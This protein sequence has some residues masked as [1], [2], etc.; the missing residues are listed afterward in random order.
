MIQ[1][2][3]YPVFIGFDPSPPPQAFH[4]LIGEPPLVIKVSVEALLNFHGIEK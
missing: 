3:L 1:H 4:P 2:Q